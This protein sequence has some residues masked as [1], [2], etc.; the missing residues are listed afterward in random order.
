MPVDSPNESKPL[1][2]I[3][4]MLEVERNSTSKKETIEKLEYE[5]STVRNGFRRKRGDSPFVYNLNLK[6]KK[7][8]KQSNFT[9]PDPWARI[10]GSKNTAAIYIDGIATTA[11]YDTGAELQ[12]ISKQFCEDNN[13]KIQPIEKLTECSTMNGSIFGYD[14]FVEVNVQIP[15]R[16]FSEDHLFLVTSE[17]S[18]QKEIPVVVGTYFISSL[19]KYLHKLDKEEFETLDHT[20]QQAYHSWVEAARIRDKYG[21]E[22]SLGFVKTTKPV[23]IHAGTSKEIHGLTK[24]KHDGFAVNCISEPAIGHNLPKGLKL[25]PGYSPLGPGSCRVSTVIENSTDTEITIPARAVVHQLGLAN[26]IPKLIYP[27]DDYDNE[28]EEL[29]DTDEGLTCK[30]FE[31][32]KAVSEE[33]NVEL[34]QEME[35][36]FTKVEIED[37]G[38][39]SEE[40]LKDQDQRSS[41][42][43][44]SNLENGIDSKTTN[45]EEEDDGS[46]ILDII[47]LS[48]LENWPEHLQIEAKEMLKR[49]A[50]TFSKNDLDMGRTNLVKH[51]IKLTDP[52]PFKETYRRIPPQMYDEVKAH[53]QDMFDLGAIRPSNSPWASAIVLVRKKDGRPR[54]CID[55]RRLNNRTVKDA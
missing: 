43:Q 15:G 7:E 5:I 36:N 47:D 28:S 51:H 29:D 1:R 38:E 13:L 40:D 10:V 53:I 44:Y 24:I 46:W 11:L 33:L 30:Q 14:G 16:H 54:F 31:H 55:L 42:P 12:L 45:S 19:S 6:I 21:C 26:M 35:N 2:E 18:H 22:P 23:I 37:L 27:G 20:V 41:K 52:V 8:K 25:V 9:N 34:K 39:D 48:G 50:K 32:H 4:Q 3:K 49:N 17:I